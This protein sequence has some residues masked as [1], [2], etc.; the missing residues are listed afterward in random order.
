MPVAHNFWTMS[1]SAK[2]NVNNWS[3]PLTPTL[4]SATGIPVNPSLLPTWASVST[5]GGT[6]NGTGIIYS[7]Q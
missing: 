2:Y 7:C 3:A 4:G 1:G 6:G 5:S